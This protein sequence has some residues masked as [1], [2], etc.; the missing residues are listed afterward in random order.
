MLP[1]TSPSMALVSQHQVNEGRAPLRLDGAPGQSDGMRIVP[2]NSSVAQVAEMVRE[3]LDA[4]PG[5]RLATLVIWCHGEPG[6]L[7][8]CDPPVTVN[9]LG[10]WFAAWVGRIDEVILIA[11]RVAA[12]GTIFDLKAGINAGGIPASVA[13]SPQVAQTMVAQMDGNHF[14]SRLAAG[15]RSRVT[16]GTATQWN[17]TMGGI[18]YPSYPRNRIPDF[19]GDVFTWGPNGAIIDM[20]RNPSGRPYRDLDGS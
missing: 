19:E 14:C 20:R 18:G 16:A 7:H 5:R 6:R 8:L 9:R 13:Q 10:P 2:A 11:C 17:M 4:L 3:R 12:I 15:L 1:I